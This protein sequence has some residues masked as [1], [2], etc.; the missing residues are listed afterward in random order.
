MT[1]SEF[2]LTSS[3]GYGLTAPRRCIPLRRLAGEAR[4][5]YLLV[6][7]H[8]PLVGQ[9]WL[10]DAQAAN[11]AIL[12]TRHKGASLFP[13]THWPVY[14]HVARLLVPY[15]DQDVIRTDQMDEVGWGELYPTEEAARKG[16]MS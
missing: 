14:V 4:D 5:D 15:L 9:G 10:P 7:I 1:A 11:T 6:T 3:E 8:P 13:I 2:Y 16:S 12:A